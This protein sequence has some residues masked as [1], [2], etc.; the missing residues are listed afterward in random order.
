MGCLIIVM[1]QKLLHKVK[2]IS[3]NKLKTCSFAKKKTGCSRPH[4]EYGAHGINIARTHMLSTK[5]W[6]YLLHA[7]H[8]VLESFE[9][10]SHD[11]FIMIRPPIKQMSENHHLN[12]PQP[13]HCKQCRSLRCKG[14]C[15]HV[16]SVEGPGFLIVLWAGN[17]QLCSWLCWHALVQS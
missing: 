7:R 14:A 15:T 13:P 2:T 5:I 11:R 12:W 17:V 9:C 6:K 8:P 3:E 16:T 10:L 1:S 4:S